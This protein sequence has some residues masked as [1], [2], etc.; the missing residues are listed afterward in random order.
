MVDFHGGGTYWRCFDQ[1]YGAQN[2]NVIAYLIPASI[3]GILLLGI[4]K[5]VN[6]LE[7]F[8]V[9]AKEGIVSVI[10][11]APILILMLT[12]LSMFRSSGAIHFL[13]EFLSPICSVLGIPPELIPLAMLRPISGSGSI[14]QLSD[15]LQTYGADSAIGRMASVLAASSETTFYTYAL[16]SGAAGVSRLPY[17]LTCGLI[18]DLA[19][20]IFS[21][22]TVRLFFR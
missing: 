14:A 2:M 22:L 9:G 10:Q 20:F 5:R 6:I 19:A 15:Y 13:S 17:A 7:E 1:N 18:S 11:V 16:Y 4:W 8:A 3:I 12:A 21:V